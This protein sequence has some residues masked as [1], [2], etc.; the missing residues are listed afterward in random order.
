MS[1]QRVALF[2]DC[3]LGRLARWLRLLGNDVT[4]Y[5]DIEDDDILQI[6]E[7][8]GNILLTK[9]IELFHRAQKNNSRAVLIAREKEEPGDQLEE[10]IG[11]I[12]DSLTLDPLIPRCVQCGAN[13]EKTS[14]EKVFQA[15]GH[16]LKREYST[17]YW[18]LR[19]EKPYWR[20]VKWRDFVIP[21]CRFLPRETLTTIEERTRKLMNATEQERWMIWV[22]IGLGFAWLEKDPDSFKGISL[23]TEAVE[24][25]KTES[26]LDLS[27]EENSIL[28]RIKR[29]L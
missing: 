18:C 29:M 8:Q 7:Q 6:L 24:F 11:L 25:Y 5:N 23:L 27:I 1:K 10:I 21:V 12:A 13:L 3:M 15:L 16:T 20:G 22:L 14:K 19:C 2:A 9:D 4:Y 28:E 17:Y 26:T